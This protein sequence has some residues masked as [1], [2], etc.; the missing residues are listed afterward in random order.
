MIVDGREK[1]LNI[2]L[3]LERATAIVRSKIV[4]KWCYCAVVLG[5]KTGWG[6][7]DAKTSMDLFRFPSHDKRTK[8]PKP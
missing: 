5:A 3:I 4:F 7:W 8:E 1:P 2:L 6:V